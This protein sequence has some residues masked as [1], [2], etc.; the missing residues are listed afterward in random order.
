MVYHAPWWGACKVNYCIDGRHYITYE[1]KLRR[2]MPK[3]GEGDSISY[4]RIGFEMGESIAATGKEMHLS[5]LWCAEP[6]QEAASVRKA[7]GGLDS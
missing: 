4:M 6:K 2:T 3:S 7:H 1:L 5:R